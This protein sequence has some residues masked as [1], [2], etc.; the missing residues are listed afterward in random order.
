MSAPIEFSC[1]EQIATVTLSRPDHGNTIDPA[2]ARALLEAAKRCDEDDDIRCVVLTG[3]GK[4]FCGGGDVSAFAAAGADVSAFLED[5]AE[6]LHAAIM[7]L[8]RM[9]KPLITLVN[10]PAAGAGMSLAMIGDV[11]LATRSAHFSPAYT[12]LGL[13]PDG[14]MSWLLPRVVGL[15]RAQEIILSN[16][17][18]S[19]DE[20]ER[21]GIVTRIVD[22]E[23]L[24][25]SG[26]ELAAKLAAEPVAALGAVRRLLL[27]SYDSTL[28][29]QL[30]REM[31]S[32]AALGNSEE[33]RRRVAAFVARRN[34]NG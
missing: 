30:E 21:I 1:T 10:G 24:L 15:R 7:R 25:A 16:R 8:M 20:A 4:L 29:T 12:A 34:S 33:S 28:E 11:A 14:G 2:L 31:R 5:L 32:I 22:G 27:E 17:R 18:V 23:Q 26:A 19:S 13:S 6:T 3:R 9:R